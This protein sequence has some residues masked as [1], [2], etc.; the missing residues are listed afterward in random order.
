MYREDL[1]VIKK[2]LSE[3]KGRALPAGQSSEEGGARSISASSAGKRNAVPESY[4]T[5]EFVHG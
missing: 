5:M 4:L 2:K 3:K 1:L